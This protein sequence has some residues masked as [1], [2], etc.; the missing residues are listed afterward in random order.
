MSIVQAQLNNHGIPASER[1]KALDRM[2]ADPGIPKDATTSSFWLQEPHP[3]FHNKASTSLPVEAD[4]VIIGSGVTGASIA[5]TLLESST[6]EQI[7]SQPRILMLEARDICSGAT[8]RNGGH[9]LENA[10]EYADF[11]DEFGEDAARK[12]IRFRLA[13]LREMLGV[14]EELG[15]TEIAQARKVQFLSAYFG[16]ENWKS[17]KERLERFKKGMS[18]ESKEW[19][20]YERDSIPEEFKL[21]R[22]NGVIA[23]PAGALWPYKFV[24]GVL[25]RLMEDYPSEFQVADHTSVTAI[26]DNRDTDDKFSLETNRGTVHARHVIHCTNAHVGHL[27]PGL[28]GRIFPVRGQMSSQTPGDK[29][30][31]QGEKHSWIFNYDRG[32]DYLTQLPSGQMMFGGGFA[33]GE[34]LGIADLGV[35]ADNEMSLAIDI[36][37]SGALS[38]VFGRESWG[39]VQGNP[40]Q[41]M[42]TGNMGFSADGFPWVGK[43]PS[44]LTHRN[45][46]SDK[47]GE[48]A[49]WVCAA[50]G[51]EGMVQAWLSGKALAAMLLIKDGHSGKDLSW[52]PEQLLVTEERV[53]N[54]K[55]P[56]VVSD[57]PQRHANL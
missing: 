24:T 10:D 26:H 33:Q 57:P 54:A 15:L 16:D 28:R 40:I 45:Q 53:K 31:L 38:A 21:S 2:H 48:G 18:E 27:V 9:I 47:A 55:L 1:Q 43:L 39:R 5:R 34:S 22:A 46:T 19:I 32:F 17:A 14:A 23:G 56:H 25:S 3:H 30:P 29:F 42:W 13:H 11:A 6:R 44:S 8:G 4:V 36:H 50:F 37:L 51:G 35:P 20:A 49:E 52:F 7:S 41:A 12:L